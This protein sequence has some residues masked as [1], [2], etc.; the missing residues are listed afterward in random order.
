MGNLECIL[1]LSIR[2][3]SVIRNNYYLWL[4]ECNK[5][6]K[7]FVDVYANEWFTITKCEDNELQK[8]RNLKFW[9]EHMDFGIVS[10]WTMA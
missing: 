3:V 1:G 9:L 6:N 4:D 8:M 7:F 5:W 2:H 10:I